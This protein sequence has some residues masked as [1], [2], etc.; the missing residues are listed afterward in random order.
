MPSRL[1][2]YFSMTTSAVWYTLFPRKVYSLLGRKNNNMVIQVIFTAPH[3]VLHYY[4]SI[5]LI[6]EFQVESSL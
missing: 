6:L 2:L 4:L 3:L 1:A 5:Y